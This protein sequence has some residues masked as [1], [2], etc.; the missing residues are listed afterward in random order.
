MIVGTL[1]MQLVVRDA[2]S[3]K[4]KRRVLKSLKDRL[5]SRFNVSVAETDAL[6]HR[7]QAF[8]AVAMV[9]NDRRFVESA[10]S[11]VVDHVRA[12]GG[13][14]LIDYELETWPAG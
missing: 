13:A 14:S 3:L 5:H 1:Q 8:L 9:S 12:H 7:Q 10:L 4:D 6:D 11:K 2:M